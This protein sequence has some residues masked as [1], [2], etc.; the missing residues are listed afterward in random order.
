MEGK[1]NGTFGVFEMVKA[2]FISLLA[3]VSAYV[4][5]IILFIP[6]MFMFDN[7]SNSNSVEYSFS[8]D[9]TGWQT[10][11]VEDVCAFQV[12][13][14]WVVT[15]YDNVIWLTDKPIDEEDFI[16]YF[17]GVVYMHGE[18]VYP[19]NV[20]TSAFNNLS[21]NQLGSFATQP[22][23][24]LSYTLGVSGNYNYSTHYNLGNRH[25]W[26]MEYYYI[27]DNKVNL[28]AIYSIKHSSL[29]LYMLAWDGVVELDTVGQIT[30]SF[31][32]A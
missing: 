18:D 24:F 2:L 30:A 32:R 4:V 13:G 17:A 20:F 3:G 9:Y 5:M 8:E 23:G 11:R 6:F 10:V 16:I 25:A 26:L 1:N 7:T 21:S 31:T 14:D 29:S 28:Y 27:D 15:Q 12:P 19:Q 22:F